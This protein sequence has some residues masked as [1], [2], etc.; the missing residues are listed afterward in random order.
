MTKG[1]SSKPKEPSKKIAKTS[2]TVDQT[3]K[4]TEQTRLRS[5]EF[6][7]QAHIASQLTNMKVVKSLILI[8]ETRKERKR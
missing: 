8:R 7:R 3:P 5:T 4:S 2:A 1:P 6:H